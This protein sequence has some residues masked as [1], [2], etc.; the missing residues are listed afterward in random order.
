MRQRTAWACYAFATLGWGA[1]I[2]LAARDY[3]GTYDWTYRVMSALASRKSNPEGAVWFASAILVAMLAL[4]PVVTRIKRGTLAEH[5][6]AR[7]AGSALRIATVCGVLVGAERLIFFHFSS[8]VRKGHE[9]LALISFLGFYCGILGLYI[10]RVRT[11]AASLLPTV[12]VVAPL[13]AIGV[14]EMLLYVGQRDL[15]WADRDWRAAGTSL[16]L[17]FSFWQWIGAVVLWM[18]LGHLL[19]LFGC[20]PGGRTQPGAT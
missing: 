13:L 6:L 4:W 14:R 12:I 2:F 11:R 9:L 8:I 1:G 20:A 18:A 15:G 7:F 16:W 3:P 5:R 17:S 10:H 19:A